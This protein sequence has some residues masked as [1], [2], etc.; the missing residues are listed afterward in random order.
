M[1]TYLEVPFE[2]KDAVKRL[3]AKWEAGS[4]RWYIEDQS[5]LRPFWKWLPEKGERPVSG[6]KSSE[7]K[8]KGKKKTKPKWEE[9]LNKNDKRYGRLNA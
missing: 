8:K 7:A 5:D 1:K 2:E 3:G 4:R 6:G 9:F